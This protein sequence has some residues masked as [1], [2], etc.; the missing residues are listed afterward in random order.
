MSHLILVRHSLPDII[1]TLPASQWRL[2]VE[3]QRRCRILAD[4]LAI[5]RP[6]AMVTSTEPKA[7]ETGQL[8]AERLGLSQK[9]TVGLHEHERP[10]AGFGTR[11]QFEA[12]VAG[13]FARP[14]ELIFGAETA[15]QAHTRFRK[16]VDGVLAGYPHQTV[17][18]VSH[19]TVMS[20]FM[21]RAT[22][23]EPF[24][25]WWRLGLPAFVVLSLPDLALEVFV[26]QV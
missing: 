17:A 14:D 5:Y 23:L 2:S 26:E 21:A 8:V 7:I 25:F 16:A 22:G 18:I 3:G 19:G 24:P 4:R 20:L 12:S 9:T 11:E 1:P 10:D 15:D 6:K 13:L